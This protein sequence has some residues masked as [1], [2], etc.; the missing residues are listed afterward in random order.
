MTKEETETENVPTKVT[1]VSNPTVWTPHSGPPAPFSKVAEMA[2]AEA[3][4]IKADES[5]DQ[6]RPMVHVNDEVATAA[7]GSA[8]VWTPHSTP[9]VSFAAVVAGDHPA[10]SVLP[11]NEHQSSQSSISTSTSPMVTVKSPILQNDHPLPIISSST[12]TKHSGAATTGLLHRE[13]APTIL[14]SINSGFNLTAAP[15]SVPSSSPP[16]TVN[17]SIPPKKKLAS[18]TK[19]AGDAPRRTVATT[20]STYQKEP[21]HHLENVSTS[22]SVPDETTSLLSD[23]FTT[24]PPLTIW[25]QIVSPKYFRFFVLFLAML[26]P[27]GG[28]VVKSSMASLLPTIFKDPSFELTHAQA[29]ALQSA[30]S[31][32]NLFLPFFGG[33]ALDFRS[34]P[35]ATMFFLLLTII[36]QIFFTAAVHYHSYTWALVSRVLFGIGEG[37]TV[38]SQGSIAARYF[39]GRELVFAIGVC[40]SAH[41]LSNWIARAGVVPAAQWLGN[42][43]WSLLLAAFTCVVS[44]IA[45]MLFLRLES[46]EKKERQ[47]QN[48]LYG[49]VP[50]QLGH[51]DSYHLMRRYSHS[52]Y[53]RSNSSS[54][55]NPLHSPGGSIIPQYASLPVCFAIL[56]LL[57]LVHSNSYHL[58]DYISS[59]FI[60]TKYNVSIE[61]AGYLASITSACAIF[62][63]PVAGLILDRYGRKM[64][65]VSVCSAITCTSFL[66]LAFT[67]ITPILPLLMLS[68]SQSFVPTIL[69][70]SVPQLTPSY[71]VGTAYGL[72]QVM[73]SLGAVVGHATVGWVVDTQGSVSGYRTDLLGF[74]GMAATACL[75]ANLL[76]VLDKS[77]GGALNR[78][79]LLSRVSTEADEED[80]EI[81]NAEYRGYNSTL[82]KWEQEWQEKEKKAEEE[83]LGLLPKV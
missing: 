62:L 54:S 6:V 75:F 52:Q 8:F 53:H 44:L 13:N 31:V 37:N 11:Y 59:D 4:A 27:S 78:P 73:E 34:A 10:D 63:C 18:E 50:P 74:A 56:C 28:H 46:E 79:N 51:Q 12:S 47:R 19:K 26:I 55:S 70:S 64:H 42:Y 2:A 20:Q 65:V 82:S 58:F 1:E 25:Q 76:S 30:I 24:P 48:S 33:L 68:L 15:T 57:H 9:P 41:E 83:E 38:V 5:N 43:E 17:P 21:V 40:E 69:R 7:A 71:L 3:E 80:P 16:S 67:D 81:R 60:K 14:S 66:L 22:A 23:S 35:R 45:G 61:H 72:Y 49:D 36:G 32:P 39:S 29:G 77:R